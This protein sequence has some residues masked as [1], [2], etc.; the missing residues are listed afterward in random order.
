M[1]TMKFYPSFENF[2]TCLIFHMLLPLM[3]IG[4]EYI[5][6]DIISIKSITIAASMYS[7][8]IGI[9]SRNFLLF[10]I[11]IIISIVFAFAFGYVSAYIPSAPG[12]DQIESI[13][14]FSILAYYSIAAIFIFH[15][16]ERIK[17]HFFQGEMFPPFRE[18]H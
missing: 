1:S 8:S 18:K 12:I 4:L 11:S 6:S 15:G 16:I 14:L 10:G 5:I 2:F 9:S 17:R 3:P 7:I 13:K